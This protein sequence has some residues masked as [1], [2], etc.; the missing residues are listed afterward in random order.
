MS[1]PAALIAPRTDP[2]LSEQVALVLIALIG[3]YS[4]LIMPFILGA[5][6]ESFHLSEARAGQY[7]S[8]QL[9]AMAIA[10][11]VVSTRLRAG[12]SVRPLLVIAIAAISIANAVCALHATPLALALARALTGLGEGAVMAAAGAAVCATANPHR[13]FWMIGTAVAVVASL[14]LVATPWLMTYAGS[15]SVFWVLAVVPLMLLPSLSRVPRLGAASETSLGF[16]PQGSRWS[17]T[18][19]LVAFLLLWCGASGLWVYAERIGAHQ[20][21]TAAQ[22]G[23]W[24]G[25]GQL[26]GIAGPLAAAWGGLRLGLRW[27]LVAGCLGMAV[28]AVFFIF[29]GNA[30]LYGLGGC[31]ASFWIMF[32]VPC[33][34][35]RMA[36]VD[37]SG[38]TVAASAGFYTV[39]FGIA[40][41][42]VAAITTEGQGYAPVAIFC[43]AC[44]LVSAVL[45][46]GH[47]RAAV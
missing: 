3:E 22:I 26:A 13:L 25:I 32:V 1:S 10:S 44:F 36:S 30:W 12:Q 39:G 21:L 35:S 27:A 7:V 11:I 40:P 6:M 5:M 45:A 43:G 4:L 24:L 38:R 17:S 18:S 16:I 42:I 41:L 29:G 8:L 34:R 23:L 33:F 28:A 47:R 9:L 2:R 14:A 15:R 20:G 19:L 31:L 37:A 46:G